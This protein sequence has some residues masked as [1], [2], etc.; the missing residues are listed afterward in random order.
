MKT[1]RQA[2]IDE[3]YWPIP[4]GFVDNKLIERELDGDKDFT[5][6][7]AKSAQY[8]G[9][10]ADCLLSLTQSFSLSEADKSIGALSDKDKERLLVRVKSLYNEIGEKP[11]IGEPTV[12]IE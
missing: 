4:M 2:L 10:L 3:I 9:C 11:A 1:I 6:E 7:V 5:C 12:Y 8:K